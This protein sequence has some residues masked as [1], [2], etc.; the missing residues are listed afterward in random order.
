MHRQRSIDDVACRAIK[1]K[2]SCYPKQQVNNNKN[3]DGDL[4]HPEVVCELEW[5]RPLRK[6]VALSFRTQIVKNHHL[7]GSMC[8]SLKAPQ[9]EEQV[10]KE[11]NTSWKQAH[12]VNP[13]QKTSSKR[14]RYL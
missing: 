11:L 13:A 5:P 14:L 10:A 9:E 7:H 8:D 3:R 12:C 6:H 4:T 1:L 2:L